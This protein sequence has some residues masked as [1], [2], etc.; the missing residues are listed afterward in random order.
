M[1][2][3]QPLAPIRQL[4]GNGNF[5]R[6]KIAVGAKDL[7]GNLSYELVNVTNASGRGCRAQAR[8]M[9][10]KQI[11]QSIRIPAEDPS[12]SSAGRPIRDWLFVQS[13]SR[14]VGRI[15][16]S[17]RTGERQAADVAGNLFALQGGKTME[18]RAGDNTEVGEIE[19]FQIE[20]IVCM[21][22]RAVGLNPWAILETAGHQRG[23]MPEFLPRMDGVC[24]R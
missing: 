13:G 19:I 4:Q 14:L 23:R 11:L 17:T 16:R 9:L 1:N 2:A 7:W 21:T 8:S 15:P 12:E 18:T 24:V 5:P 6:V 3:G 10:E 22:V 20:P